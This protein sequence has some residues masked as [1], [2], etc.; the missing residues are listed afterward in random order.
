MVFHA[1]LFRPKPHTSSSGVHQTYSQFIHTY[2]NTRRDMSPS[3]KSKAIRKASR[4][5]MCFGCIGI[6]DFQNEC[7]SV[8]TSTWWGGL[9]WCECESTGLCTKRDRSLILYSHGYVCLPLYLPEISFTT[10]WNNILFS[11]S[12]QSNFTFIRLTIGKVCTLLC[13][14]LRIGASL[15][16][17]SEMANGYYKNAL[18]CSSLAI[19]YIAT[20]QPGNNVCVCR[21]SGCV[22]HG[23]KVF[24]YVST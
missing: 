14:G 16:N 17:L 23:V 21:R 19:A 24:V 10:L 15:A 9:L 3:K 2:K 1:F 7:V 20:T 8:R 4:L 12:L 22:R 5:W 11:S 13:F 18:L 6:G